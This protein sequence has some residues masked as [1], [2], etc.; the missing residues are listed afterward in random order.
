MQNYNKMTIR[1]C[2]SGYAVYKAKNHYDSCGDCTVVNK[3]VTWYVPTYA[4]PHKTA[5]TWLAAMAFIMESGGEYIE[6]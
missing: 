4:K 3:R 6:L 1:E 2:D 5:M